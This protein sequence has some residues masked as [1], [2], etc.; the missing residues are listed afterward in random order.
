MLDLVG[1]GEDRSPSLSELSAYVHYLPDGPG[2][3][4]DVGDV[5]G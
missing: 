2:L 4:G 3:D 5:W 1:R